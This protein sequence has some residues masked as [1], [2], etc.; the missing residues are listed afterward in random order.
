MSWGGVLGEVVGCRIA[1]PWWE[2]GRAPC[3]VGLG[4][5]R[6]GEFGEVGVDG[7][8]VGVEPCEARGVDGVG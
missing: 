6:R 1:V 5:W 3:C 7:A 8:E 4:G 2:G